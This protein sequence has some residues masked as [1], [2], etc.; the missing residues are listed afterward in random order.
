MNKK[1]F[2]KYINIQLKNVPLEKFEQE[3]IKMQKVWLP[4]ILDKRLKNYTKCKLCGKY[5]KEKDFES[6]SIEEIHTETTYKDAGYGDDDKMG[7]VEYLVTYQICPIC[8]NKE[9]K[10]KYYIKTIREW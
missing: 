8:Q 7:E 10:S 4:Q 1:D 2:E 3:L 9:L 6:E 5:S